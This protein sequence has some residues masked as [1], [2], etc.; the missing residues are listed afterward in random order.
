MKYA[1]LAL[2]TLAAPGLAFA[3]EIR[4]SED[5]VAAMVDGV[6][7]VDSA[8]V[9]ERIDANEDLLILDVRT[10]AEFDAGH[11][12]SATHIPRGVIE[13]RMAGGNYDADTEIIVTCSH[14]YRAASV[15]KLLKEMGYENVNA[16]RGMNAWLDDGHKVM[17]QM[18]MMSRP[19]RTEAE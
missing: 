8:Y 6:D 2:L 9:A 17:T 5:V 12:R 3:G 14:G 4:S 19:A 15:T 13:F 7:H 16:H 10:E 11:I 18:G 1:A